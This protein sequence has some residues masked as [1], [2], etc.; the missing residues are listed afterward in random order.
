MVGPLGGGGLKTM[1]GEPLNK[2]NTSFNDLS[3]LL[4][5]PHGKLKN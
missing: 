2:E 4:P 5:E 1:N 3:K